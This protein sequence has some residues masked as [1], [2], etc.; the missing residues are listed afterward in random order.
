[1]LPPRASAKFWQ[2]D[3]GAGVGFRR[4]GVGRPRVEVKRCGGRK[5]MAKVW[6]EGRKFVVL[7]KCEELRRWLKEEVW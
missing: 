4:C 3:R 2:V 1:M 7:Q 6:E 5:S